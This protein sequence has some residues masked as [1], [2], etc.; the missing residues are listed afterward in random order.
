MGIQTKT[1]ADCNV[2]YIQQFVPLLRMVEKVMLRHCL[3]W[4]SKRT[5][6]E[7]VFKWFNKQLSGNEFASLKHS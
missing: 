2:L 3:Q 5:K 7:L 6:H 4:R 1:T